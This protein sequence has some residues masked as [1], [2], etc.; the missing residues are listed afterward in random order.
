MLIYIVV[1]EET[2][3]VEVTHLLCHLCLSRLILYSVSSTTVVCPADF[4]YVRGGCYQITAPSALL[5]WP[6]AVAACEDQ[7]AYLAV[8]RSAV[9]TRW[10][11]EIFS[12][13]GQITPGQSMSIWLGMND[14]TKE[15]AWQ[16]VDGGA[17]LSFTDWIYGQPNNWD[18]VSMENCGAFIVQ[19][20]G[21]WADYSCNK[22]LQALCKYNETVSHPVPNLLEG[23]DCY[24]N[25]NCFC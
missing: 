16:P 1:I 8:P 3:A 2:V 12:I 17:A 24:C 10:L 5:S 4:V 18:G 23:N 13:L 14:V 6:E 25:C 7:S 9:E 11:F 21:K 20:Q 19:A 15:T 22:P